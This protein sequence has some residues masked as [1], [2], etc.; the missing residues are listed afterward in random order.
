[1]GDI[2]MGISSILY[3]ATNILPGPAVVPIL[4]GPL[5]TLLALLPGILIAL[6]G[7]FVALFKP[8]TAVKLARLMWSQK[9]PLTGFACVVAVFCW[10]VP[11]LFPAAHGKAADAESVNYPLY[12]GGPARR[13]WQPGAADPTIGGRVWSYDPAGARTVFSSPAVT[14]KYVYGASVNYGPLSDKGTIFCLDSETGKEVW[15][16]DVGDLR[17]VFSSPVVSGNYLI[18]GEGLHYI[19]NARIVC[20]D[21]RT[22]KKIWAF[23]TK[24]H[25]ESSACIQDGKV[26]VGAGKDG[27]YALKLEGDGKGQPIVLW[28]KTKEEA[29]VDCESAPLAFENRVYVG[30]GRN[31]DA[32]CCLD[33]E[34]GQELWRLKTKAPV[35]TPPVIEGGKL[36]VGVGHG[37]FVKPAEQYGRPPEGELLCI[38]IKNPDKPLWSFPTGRTILAAPAVANGRVYACSVDGCIYC[39]HADGAHSG[40]LIKKWDAQSPIMTSPAVADGHV[41]FST[42]SGILYALDAESLTP[43]WTQPLWSQPPQTDDVNFFSSPTAANGHI[44]VGSTKDGLLCIGSAGKPPESVWA[45]CLGGNGLSGFA[46]QTPVARSYDVAWTYPISAEGASGITAPP[47]YLNRKLYV[48]AVNGNTASLIQLSLDEKDVAR[49]PSDGWKLPSP[50]PIYISAAARQNIVFVAD[51]KPGDTS[52]RLR[53]ISARDGSESWHAA[54]ETNAPGDFILSGERLIAT[55]LDSGLSAYDLRS[56]AGGTELWKNAVGLCV[57]MPAADDGRVIVAL[58]DPSR[59]ALLDLESGAVLWTKELNA[60]PT[61][62]PILFGETI[63]VG[64]SGGALACQLLDGKT[65]WHQ[66]EAGNISSPLVC[67][68]GRVAAANSEGRLNLLDA[69]TGKQLQYI[70]QTP[71]RISPMLG[72]GKMFYFRS[73]ALNSV[74]LDDS[75]NFETHFKLGSKSE[76]PLTPAILVE[77]HL[78][79]GT[80]KGLLCAKPRE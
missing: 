76:K 1:M 46:D 79:V 69:A 75:R 22:G 3:P 26:F 77:G 15:R 10:S 12:R 4:V 43:C 34:T 78:F 70:S 36:Y 73:G 9:F 8:S 40:E 44:Y 5:Q 13:G 61:T 62:G 27:Y 64:T 7:L 51:G 54:I 31:N 29:Y 71:A 55:N 35:F 60:A 59:L 6:S 56:S 52:R 68:E 45:G 28:H 65:L 49:K 50:N 23:A 32:V 53:A 80:T 37:D 58:R 48:P 42:R 74:A 17:S 19:K 47:A 24:G 67:A 11:Q 21:R 33:A 20:L 16:D 2:S 41:Y 57:G 66:T 38:D 39:V 25:V 63:C 30:L 72:R 18:C 14:G